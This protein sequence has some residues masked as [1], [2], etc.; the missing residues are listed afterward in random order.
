MDA[1]TLTGLYFVGIGVGPVGGVVAG[2]ANRETLIVRE[3]SEGERLL[4]VPV[5]VAIE[6]NFYHKERDALEA[7]ARVCREAWNFGPTNK[8]Q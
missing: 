1:A 5:A 8:P 3:F 6:W 4:Y 2:M 7:F